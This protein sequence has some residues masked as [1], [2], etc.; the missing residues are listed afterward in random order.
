MSFLKSM[1]A[2]GAALTL[3]AAVAVSCALPTVAAFAA[4]DTTAGAVAGG[5]VTAPGTVQVENP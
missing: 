2:R 5:G 1:M 3:A 4:D